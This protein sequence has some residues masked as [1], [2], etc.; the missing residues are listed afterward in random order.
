MNKKLLKNSLLIA[1]TA[2]LFTACNNNNQEKTKVPKD[3]E[4][5]IEYKEMTQLPSEENNP[6]SATEGIIVMNVSQEGKIYKVEID[7]ATMYGGRKA[8]EVAMEETKCP[9]GKV[10]NGDCAPSLN[11]NFYI[12]N[13]EKKTETLEIDANAKIEVY[14]AD[15]KREIDLEGF[16]NLWTQTDAFSGGYQFFTVESGPTGKITKMSSVYLP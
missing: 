12:S 3:Q 4:A 13:P 16:Y 11:N 2:I 14:T 8:I 7:K 1:L 5:P 9:I 10:F 15:E 6:S